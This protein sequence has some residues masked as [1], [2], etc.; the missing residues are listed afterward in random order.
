MK[1][2]KMHVVVIT[3]AW[4]VVLLLQISRPG[5]AKIVKKDCGKYFQ[6]DFYC[7]YDCRPP[8]ICKDIMYHGNKCSYCEEA[9]ELDVEQCDGIHFTGPCRGFFGFSEESQAKKLCKYNENYVR[10][11]YQPISHKYMTFRCF[12]CMYGLYCDD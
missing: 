6:N 7:N 12:H 10:Y 2:R 9:K 1:Q 3:L 11:Y 8:G 5:N 4:V